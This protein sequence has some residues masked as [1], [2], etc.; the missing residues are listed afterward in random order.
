MRVARGMR[1]GRGIR[2]GRR[3]GDERVVLADLK[4]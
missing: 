2:F 1:G 4:R 3:M